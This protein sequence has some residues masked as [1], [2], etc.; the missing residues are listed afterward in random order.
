MTLH[1]DVDALPRRTAHATH[2]LMAAGSIAYGNGSGPFTAA[3]V[4]IYD[5][6]ALTVRSTAA[7]LREA[8]KW[9]LVIGLAGLWT[10]GWLAL[11]HRR[12]FEERYLRDTEQL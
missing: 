5:G 9:G 8:A 1:F 3:E 7:A 10:P 11:E 2:A 4:C 6:E 12:E